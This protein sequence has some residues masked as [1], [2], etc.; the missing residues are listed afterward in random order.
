MLARLQ[1]R[2]I[3]IK[4]AVITLAVLGAL[5]WLITNDALAGIEGQVTS[6]M[7]RVSKW[8]MPGM[9]LIGLF[10]NMTLVIVVPY[11]LPLFTLVIYADSLWE[12]LALGAATGL[13]GGIGEVTSYAVA[14][15][16]VKQ[17]RGLEES[18]LFRWTKRT[19]DRH[20]RAIPI[21]IWLT[22]ATPIP[23]A[24]IIVPLA[25][26]HHSWKKMIVPMVTG[27]IAQ[28]AVV[29][30]IFRLAT[31]NAQGLVS[32]DVNF[33]LTA[34]LVALFVIILAYQIERARAAAKN[35]DTPPAHQG[36]TQEMI[37]P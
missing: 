20:P 26:I 35:G 28:N 17:V 31:N 19:I 12:V 2:R 1:T 37:V 33:S 11:N 22:S 27:K 23:D 25:M 21:F 15:T 18:G 32:G 7:E 10:S 3:E 4:Y 9:F 14:H 6:I 24:A 36:E 13:G 16:L 8:G 34:I 29:A 30:L 5:G